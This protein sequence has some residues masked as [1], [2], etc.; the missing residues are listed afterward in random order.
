M[1]SIYDY[2]R[3]N[4]T[5][6][7]KRIVE[8]YPALHRS[9]DPSAPEMEELLR[10]PF[11]AQELAIMGVAKYLQ[12]ARSARIVAECGAGKTLMA[13]AA[14]HVHAAGRKYST[15]VMCP[16]HLVHKWAR[17]IL[18]TIPGA[19]TYIIEDL[20]NGGA[21]G[22][23]HGVLEVALRMGSTVRH[24]LHTSLPAL[25][26]MDSATRKRKLGVCS[27]FIV[28]KEKGKLGYFWKHSYAVAESGPERGGVINPDTGCAIE[29]AGERL[30][31]SDFAESRMSE[32]LEG[33]KGGHARYSALWQ[34]DRERIQRM[35]P[36]EYIGRYMKGWWDY[37]IADELHQLAGD[38][39]QG[40]GLAVLARAANKLIG[41]TGTMMGGYADD[42]FNI[43][44]RMEPKRL[45]H[46]GYAWGGHGRQEFQRDYGVI[47]TIEKIETGDNA[48][49]RSSKRTVQIIRKPGAS[50]LLFGKHLMETTAFISL[51]D[52]SDQL[53]SY[54]ETVL[55]IQMDDEL[56]RAYEK[57]SEDIRKAISEDR[58]N[59]SLRSVMLNTLLVYPDHPFG[60][61]T[62]WGK[63]YDASVHGMVRF[64]VSTPRQL[65]ETVEYA[66]ERR[67]IEDIQT[68]L[69]QGRR[70]QV[71][72]VY[73]GK[74]DVTARL[75]AKLRHAGIRAEVLRST[76]PTEKREAWYEKRIKEGVE[77]VLCHP[78]LV[79]TGL[80]LLAFPSLYFYETG[81]SLHTLRQA[82]RR[83]WR[84]GQTEPV[85][86]KFLAYRDTMQETCIR[87]M[88]KKL[89]VA[90]MM[91]GK[92]SGEGLQSLDAE[93]DM[94]SAMARELV[95]RNGVGETAD[96]IWR[97]LER[98]RTR[99]QPQG[100]VARAEKP[101]APLRLVHSKPKPD[102]L[103]PTATTVGEQMSLFA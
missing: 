99:H 29:V 82:S 40:N 78:R 81:Y 94:L 38:T 79:E 52:I 96:A 88:G 15:L 45:V 32:I 84:I 24:G 2:F 86:V 91:E 27:F 56:A 75:E 50:P 13:V 11:P 89:L 90:L 85:R 46:E 44:Y 39:A 66:K 55:Q 16:P 98:E 31:R 17:E 47:E 72:A 43:L 33:R 35:A 92:F 57:L 26:S 36:L 20:R 70:C 28:G 41:L 74:A 97:D 42:L 51:D 5:E 8:T 77:V 93:E 48:C 58:R 65:S 37:A 6:L 19:R 25:R 22:Q 67:L 62:I 95:E 54:E 59:K 30:T 61:E 3:A 21:K 23:P 49:S 71:Y 76:V 83:S 100:S 1:E 4:G 102:T 101:T 9:S 63:R 7:G 73:T 68:E 14:A 87:L 80:D 12:R 53:P 34:A 18:Q 103:W 60:I 69:A 64:H 10:P